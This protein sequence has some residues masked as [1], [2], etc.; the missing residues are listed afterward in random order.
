MPTELSRLPPGTSLYSFIQSDIQA[1]LSFV[2]A[3]GNVINT[4][5]RILHGS[6]F[7]YNV[8][9][10]IKTGSLGQG[11]ALKQNMSD[12]DLVVYLNDLTMEELIHNKINI[13]RDMNR[14]LQNSLP[15]YQR[16]SIDEFRLGI[17]LTG[18]GQIF[19]VDLLPG[20]A[21]SGD[22]YQTYRK[23]SCEPGR[24][25]AHYSVS[26]AKQQ[27]AFIQTRETKLKTLFQLM[28]YWIK[29]DLKK[30]SLQKF[31]SY[32]MTLIVIHTWEKYGS[33]AVFN[34][35]AGFKAVLQTLTE[36]GSIRR[37][38][39]VNYDLSILRLFGI[40]PGPHL[41]DPANPSCNMLHSVSDWSTVATVARRTLESPI[42]QNVT[43]R[44]NWF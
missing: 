7:P 15:N 11:T 3:T 41:I 16:L 13:L 40:P 37:V 9:E 26:F 2:N 1:N 5:A 27:K 21:I 19:D 36:Y 14:V 23:F 31:P 24:I 22:L 30:Y 25:R 4:L 20:I 35:E 33:P 32:L 44:Q 42:L 38:W 29:V 10:V 34:I 43:V 8:A 12:I 28:K 17:R 6:S 39:E 18:Y